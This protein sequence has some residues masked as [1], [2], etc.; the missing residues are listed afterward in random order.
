[1]HPALARVDHRPWPPPDRPWVGRQTW[2]D[3]LFAHWPVPAAALRSLVPSGLEID[4]RDGSSWVGLVPFR[5]TGVAPRL[6]PDLPGLSSFP[7][8]NLRLYVTRGGKPGVWF[9]SLDAANR[10][11]VWGARR[12]LHLPYF[13][14]R[15]SVEVAG[16]DGRV[17]YRSRRARGP[18]RLEAEYGPTGAPFAAAPGSLEHFLTERYCLYA[19]APDGT[20]RR[21][22]I[23][24]HPWPL[25]PASATVDAHSLLAAGGVRVEGSPPLL[26][27]A[28]C[29]DVVVWS[30]RLAS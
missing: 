25:Q 18:A 27:F 28:R 8:T 9:L 26:H 10:L 4:Q 14:A 15:M 3:L 16:G 17:R 2:R 6:S 7:E 19:A 12:F 21:L 22:E 24:H 20:L 11:A 5:M 30:P 13:F 23:H 29:L 1:V